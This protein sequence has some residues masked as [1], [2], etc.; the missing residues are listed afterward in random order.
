LAP[1]LASEGSFWIG[2]PITVKDDTPHPAP[3]RMILVTTQG[4]H[5]ITTSEA[6]FD[7]FR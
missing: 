3:R 4:E 1:F 6:L 7:I 2:A 5:Q